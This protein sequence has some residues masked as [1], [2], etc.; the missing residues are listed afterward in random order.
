MFSFD[1]Y[2]NTL[3]KNTNNKKQTTKNP[4]LLIS[5]LNYQGPSSFPWGVYN[6]VCLYNEMF[7]IDGHP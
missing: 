6:W 2:F 4:K 5:L 1:L 3:N 7:P